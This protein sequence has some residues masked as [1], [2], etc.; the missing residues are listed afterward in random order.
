VANSTHTAA[1]STPTQQLT[2]QSVQATHVNSDTEIMFLA[3]AKAGQIMNEL[4]DA[5]SEEAQFLAL[6]KFL[7]NIMKRNEK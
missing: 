6:G 3:Y 4:K 5:A 2:G 7:F 1:T